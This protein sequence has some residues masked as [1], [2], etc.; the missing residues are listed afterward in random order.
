MVLEL[1]PAEVAKK[2]TEA[3]SIPTIGIG[4]GPHTSGQVLVFQDMLGLNTDFE[5]KFLRKYLNGF[6]LIRDAINN[7][8]LDVKNNKF[9]SQ[10]E[11][12]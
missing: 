6:E 1:I 8:N 3:V 4:A 5:P 10:E 9:P 11:S 7:Y 12:Y 2:I